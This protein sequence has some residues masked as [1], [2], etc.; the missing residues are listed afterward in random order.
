MFSFIPS[1]Y[2]VTLQV[3]P[4][5]DSS[6]PPELGEPPQAASSP[7]ELHY[8]LNSILFVTRIFSVASPQPKKYQGERTIKGI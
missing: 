3:C 2:L 6:L 4:L 8:L 5:L 7:E 1:S